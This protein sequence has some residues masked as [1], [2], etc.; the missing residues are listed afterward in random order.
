MKIALCQMNPI[1]GDFEG[2]LKKIKEMITSLKETVDVCVFHELAISGYA[3]FDL[4][5]DPLFLEKQN[6]ALSELKL[7]FKS[8]LI[9]IGAVTE[10]PDYGDKPFSNSALLLYGGKIAARYDKVCLPNYDV[11]NEK[12]YFSSGIKPLVFPFK[13]KNLAITICEDIWGH[14]ELVEDTMYPKDPIAELAHYK[15][16]C[17]IN[18]SA[19]PF[20]QSK[21]K[22]RIEVCKKASQSLKVPTM[23]CCQVGAFDGVIYD[24]QSVVVNKNAELCVLGKAFVE[25]T[26]VVDLEDLVKQDL[27]FME[28]EEELFLALSLGIKDYF[29]KQGFKSC[30]LGLSGGLD[31]AVV[32][33]LAVNALGANRVYAYFLPSKYSSKASREDAT[34][35]AK[36]FNVS[37]KTCSIEKLHEA[38]DHTVKNTLEKDVY[39]L[40]DQN[41]Q[42]RIRGLLL[43]AFSN[44]SESLLLTTG[45]K[46]ELAMGYSTL[47]GDMAGALSPLGDLYKKDVYSLAAWINKNQEIIPS[48]ILK[49]APSAELKYDQK[50][51]DILPP[52]S[53]LDAV[54]KLYLEEGYSRKQIVELKKFDTEIVF[55]IISKLH[56]MEYKRAQYAPIL[57]VSK[58][59]FNVGR[60]VPIVHQL[61]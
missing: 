18:L 23:M 36:N 9:I 52:Y 20:E 39:E 28:Q 56:R 53:I 1:I 40:T 45:N 46:S 41:I 29:H 26:L 4:I 49:K 32:L 48:N 37:L 50:D 22:A 2:N 34:Q 30:L 11:F 51:E 33:A 15:I 61:Y 19:S 58:K 10:A 25:E 47:Y 35:L 54:L 17:L 5:F 60:K 44:Q 8:I 38:M 3:P 12:R 7:Q 6:Q 27:E 14:S 21:W 57:K 16:D 42:A 31:S 43:M 13:G 55:S 24:G 59:A